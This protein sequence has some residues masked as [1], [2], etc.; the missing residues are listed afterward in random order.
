MEWLEIS[1]G[2]P[3]I[4]D[5]KLYLPGTDESILPYWYVPCIFQSG[6]GDIWV[7]NLQSV[8]R[9]SL[10]K[11]KNE[12]NPQRNYSTFGSNSIAGRMIWDITE[13]EDENIWVATSEGLSMI[14]PTTNE[15]TNYK[16]TDGIST[17][18]SSNNTKTLYV[19][20]N[21]VL[22]IGTE[23]GGLN[24]FDATHGTFTRFSMDQ[25]LP[26]NTIWGILQDRERNYWMSTDRGIT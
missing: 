19:D 1:G 7:A 22:W 23:G 14:D 24:R 12:V 20:D 10:G 9:Y 17:S 13:D 16:H 5:R 21:N 15:I 18:L 11:H 25:G 2:K 26:S 8:V 3:Q 4:T 6:S